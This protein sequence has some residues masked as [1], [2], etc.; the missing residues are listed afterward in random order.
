MKTI[1]LRITETGRSSLKDQPSR[2][3]DIKESFETVEQ[4]KTYL[5]DRYRKIPNGKN[6]IYRN[7]KDDEPI[8]CGFLHSFW[9]QDISHMTPKY[10]QT[11]WIEFFEQETN[12]KYFIL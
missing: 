1:E 3:N 7:V 11:D 2:F 9:N 6:K 5:I 12:I 10:Y 8:I 4:L